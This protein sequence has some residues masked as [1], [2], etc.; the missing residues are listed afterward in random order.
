LS[1]TLF[2]T[3]ALKE[4]IG[5]PSIAVIPSMLQELWPSDKL[6]VIGNFDEPPWINRF[7]QRL[8]NPFVYRVSLA[9]HYC[10]YHFK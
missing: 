5:H 4:E 1:V 8:W 6:L 3:A 2:V 7:Y 9:L 10:P